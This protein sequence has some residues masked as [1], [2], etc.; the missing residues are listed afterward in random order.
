MLASGPSCWH[1]AVTK[2]R[3]IQILDMREQEPVVYVVDDDRAVLESLSLL[4]QSVGLNVRSYASASAF[5]AQFEPGHIGCLVLDIRMPGM[6][7]LALQQTLNENRINIPIIFVTGHGDVAMAVKA[8]KAGAV[9][10]VEK[11]VNDQT[12]LDGIDKAIHVAIRT[13]QELKGFEELRHRMAELTDREKEVLGYILSGMPNKLIARQINL[14]SRTIEAHRA[15]IFE[16]LR[17]RTLVEL[18]QLC[19]TDPQVVATDTGPK[20]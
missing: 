19:G 16:K 2:I 7:G 20:L 1:Y 18:I 14:S 12:L 15:S 3:G 8:M 9:D 13:H 4:L 5:L 10:F 11:P 6:S 17:V